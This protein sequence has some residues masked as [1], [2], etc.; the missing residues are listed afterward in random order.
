MEARP[1]DGHLLKDGFRLSRPQTKPLENQNQIA[2][3]RQRDH[4]AD[5]LTPAL[6]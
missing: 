4:F 1:S 5:R 6:P 2:T 3:I